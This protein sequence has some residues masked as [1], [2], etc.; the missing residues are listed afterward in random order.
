MATSAQKLT[1]I[2]EDDYLAGEKISDIKYEYIDGDV[3]AMSGASNNHNLI[4]GNVFLAFANHLKK[5][6]CRPYIS[7][8]KVKIGSR[9]FYPDVIVDCSNLTGDSYFTEQPKILVEVL[10]KST[11]RM[12]ETTKRMNYM[13]IPSLQEYILI[14]QDFVDVEIIRR[15]TGWLSEHYF[16]GDELTLSSIGL[17]LTVEDIYERVQNNDVKEWLE[18]QQE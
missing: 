7:D 5:Q 17:T 3:Y 9:Y 4:A 15:E 11:R 6:P 12:D 13:Q 16:L 1:F 18:S 8:M 14:E 2:S 10:S